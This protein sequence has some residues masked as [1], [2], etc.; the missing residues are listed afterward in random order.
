[1]IEQ[2]FHYTADDVKTMEQVVKEDNLNLN[3]IVLPQGESFPKH[4]A[5]ATVYM[6]VMRGELSIVLQEQDAHTY[7]RGDVLKIPEGTVMQGF[8]HR[9]ETLELWIVKLFA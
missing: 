5:N 8:N 6:T 7:R 4:T 3:H 1:M 9:E 2:L